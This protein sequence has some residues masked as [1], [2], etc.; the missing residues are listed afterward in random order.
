MS[1]GQQTSGVDDDDDDKDPHH[2]RDHQ[3]VVDHADN[4]EHVDAWDA[5]TFAWLES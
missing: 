3:C 4:E 2:H 1:W 5:Q